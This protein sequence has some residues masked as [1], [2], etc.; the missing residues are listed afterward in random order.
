ML[1]HRFRN[2]ARIVSCP[3]LLARLFRQ[4]CLNRAKIIL[5]VMDIILPSPEDIRAGPDPERVV[6]LVFT[7][8][9]CYVV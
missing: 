1:Q 5:L 4:V 9:F 3:E 2:P 8:I 7:R 6:A